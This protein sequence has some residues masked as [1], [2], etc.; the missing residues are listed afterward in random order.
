MLI[1]TAVKKYRAPTYRL[2]YAKKMRR[3]IGAVWPKISEK[4]F[5]VMPST[6]VKLMAVTNFHQRKHREFLVSWDF[7]SNRYTYHTH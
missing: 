4:R 2:G 5:F 1:N 7:V 3:E 6:S